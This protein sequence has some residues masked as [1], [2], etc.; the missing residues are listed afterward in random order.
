MYYTYG[1]TKIRDTSFVLSAFDRSIK[2]NELSTS[3]L[4]YLICIAISVENVFFFTLFK[5]IV[6]RYIRK[7]KKCQ[8]KKL[9][10]SVVR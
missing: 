1:M 4:D 8:K 2:S 9:V 10:I 5:V 3:R 6:L 7:K